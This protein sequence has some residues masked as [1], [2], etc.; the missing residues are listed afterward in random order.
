MYKQ[1]TAGRAARLVVTPYRVRTYVNSSE[2]IPYQSKKSPPDFDGDTLGHRW[3]ILINISKNKAP[4]KTIK[5]NGPISI[6]PPSY[7]PPPRSG[8]GRERVH[9]TARS[10]TKL[11]ALRTCW[12]FDARRIFSNPD[13]LLLSRP[14][15]PIS[16]WANP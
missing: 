9:Y 5:I 6:E 3:A 8:T 16:C 12:S 15:N 1:L 2:Q 11:S 10:R 4:K 13:T 14:R 7:A